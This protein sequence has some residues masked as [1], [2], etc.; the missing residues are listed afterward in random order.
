MSSKI[1][2]QNDVQHRKLRKRLEDELAYRNSSLEAADYD[3]FVRSGSTSPP[4]STSLKIPGATDS[5]SQK[6]PPSVSTSNSS[7]HRVPPKRRSSFDDDLSVPLSR[8]KTTDLG[9]LP[10][11]HGLGVDGQD[12]DDENTK[13][14]LTRTATNVASSSVGE[15]RRG[16]RNFESAHKQRDTNLDVGEPVIPTPKPASSSVSPRRKKESKGGFF[17][18]LF[19]SKGSSAS[20]SRANS[21]RSSLTSN[22][23]FSRSTSHKER[24]ASR[25]STLSNGTLNASELTAAKSATE[26]A[27]ISSSSTS[28][29]ASEAASARRGSFSPTPSQPL[30]EKFK[31][32][33][34]LLAGYLH[35]I[36]QQSKE[37]VPQPELDKSI[38]T[39]YA[40]TT[41]AH[42]NYGKGVIPP[43][44]DQPKLP[45]AFSKTPKF[46]GSIEMELYQR[47]ERERAQK[48]EAGSNGM[49]GGLLHRTKTNVVDNTLMKIMCNESDASPPLN[50]RPVPYVKPPVKYEKKPPME[51]LKDVRPL[52]KVA[53]ATTTF[54]NDPP[55]QI[56]SRHPRKGNV[57]IG[58]KGELIIHKITNEDKA[59]ATSGIVVGGSGHLKLLSEIAA[60]QQVS[61]LKDG[62]KS[63]AMSKKGSEHTIRNEDKLLA[64]KKAQNQATAASEA[65]KNSSGN[66]FS[67]DNIKIDTPM[68]RRKKQMEKP[69][70]TLKIDELYT[71][72]CHLREILP[73]PATLKQI[74]KGSTDPIPTL[75]LKNPHP[76]MIEVLAFTDFIR[77]APIICLSLDGVSLTHSMFRLILS[78]L[79][80]KRYLEKLSLRNTPIDTEGW[81][82]L[83]WFLSTNKA[84]MRLDVTE[85]PSLV[86][87]TQKT[88]KHK[89]KSKPN[90]EP[91]MVCN[92]SDRSDMNWPLLTASIIYRNGIGELILSGCK[93]GD[94]RTFS[95]LL[96][97]GIPHGRKLGL[98][99]NDLTLKQC[100]I[101]ANWMERNKKCIGID[102]GY[103]DLS[104]KLKPFIDYAKRADVN[105][106]L[107]LVS[108]NCCNLLCREDTEQMFN[109]LSKLAHLKYL[110]VSN[111]K[112]LFPGFMSKLCTY[113]PLF[114]EL[115]RLNFDDNGLDSLSLVKLCECLPLMTHLNYLSVRG[116]KLDDAVCQALCRSL[117]SSKTLFTV[118]F[119]K[120]TVSEE[121][122]HK[123]GLL[124]MKNMERTLYE[125]HNDKHNILSSFDVS[126]SVVKMRKDL[127]I[128]DDVSFGHAF[129]T[130]IRKRDS[131][132]PEE[133]SKFFKAAK[134][135]RTEMNQIISELM[136]LQVDE[137]LS[138]EGKELLI[139]LVNI[140]S[141]ISKCIELVSNNEQMK[142]NDGTVTSVAA[143]EYFNKVFETG[144]PA[145]IASSSTK[146]NEMV[147][148]KSDN[149]NLPSVT[150]TKAGQA[151]SDMMTDEAQVFRTNSNQDFNAGLEESTKKETKKT[152]AENKESYKR[153]LLSARDPLDVV[154]LLSMMRSKGLQLADIYCKG[155]DST[156]ANTRANARS[157]EIKVVGDDEG[158]PA[159]KR[160]EMTKLYDKVLKDIVKQNHVRSDKDTTK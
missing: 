17:H 38:K 95:N 91:R 116:M 3:W 125:Q 140:D 110:D 6:A 30:S 63:T 62:V 47:R 153:G 119:D 84:L 36:E 56:P 72:C 152:D 73:I 64:A 129:I 137:K 42:I 25:S 54:V 148:L 69:V 31:D 88:H 34:P 151:S 58:D 71:R 44:P 98:A 115:S 149:T 157:G 53:F 15:Q 79:C 156:S 126:N 68:V 111:N 131:L 114:S 61:D 128:P 135:M 28:V 90:D 60:E 159:D 5:A 83:C 104:G 123:F 132:P 99:Y 112:K 101:V 103:N 139:R 21:R 155:K 113:L 138:M 2:A 65:E 10:S 57:E 40:P 74:P 67:K 19:K 59:H 136:K 143:R 29:P 80:Y 24:P 150:T 46:G 49:L 87:N 158:E 7:A 117:E 124:T 43:H 121:Y 32:V 12:D 50:F 82:M 133:V 20:S 144:R 14:A 85:C 109:G 1:S 13:N 120:D 130:V 77:I 145:S 100:E 16:R 134:K 33:D 37:I 70:V 27:S 66:H 154:G 23:S 75:R 105:N 97:L 106:H 22:K 52:K 160:E 39:I 48:K 142:P 107:W 94:D 122:Q 35:D 118:D 81:R 96:D 11:M 9:N 108:L 41:C 78:A 45:S 146:D 89:K 51:P 4:P 127:N 141:S 92:E 76:S 93:I 18:R 55:Q 8:S 147:E 86:V 26:S 102:L